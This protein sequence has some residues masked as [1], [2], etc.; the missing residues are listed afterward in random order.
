[1]KIE[2]KVG[3]VSLAGISGTFPRGSGNYFS[4][5]YEG[6]EALVINLSYEDF[7]DAESQGMTKGGV[8]CKVFGYNGRYAVYVIDS[9]IPAEALTP[10]NTYFLKGAHVANIVRSIYNIDTFECIMKTHPELASKIQR[11]A[12][13]DYESKPGYVIKTITCGCCNKD[14]VLEPE[15]HIQHGIVVY[16]NRVLSDKWTV[17]INQ[18]GIDPDTGESTTMF[19]EEALKALESMNVNSL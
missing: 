15:L 3:M 13:Y 16:K 11:Q 14:H 7:K 5:N 12:S 9:R 8:D 6:S 1:M 17:E 19:G 18:D 2:F 10:F 4:I